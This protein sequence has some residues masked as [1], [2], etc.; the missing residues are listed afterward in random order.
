MRA[1]RKFLPLGAYVRTRISQ[2]LEPEPLIVRGIDQYIRWSIEDAG[3]DRLDYIPCLVVGARRHAEKD[4][5]AVY[6]RIEVKLRELAAQYRAHTNFQPSQSVPSIP[7]QDNKATF[8]TSDISPKP[9]STSGAASSTTTSPST[10]AFN[11]ELPTL[12]GLI[13]VHTIVAL[14]TLDTS[15]D[16]KEL[17]NIALI[18]YSKSDQDVWNGIAIA[19]VAVWARNQLKTLDWPEKEKVEEVDPDL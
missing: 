16:G 19:M 10:H 2:S 12:Y 9:E 8:E 5:K 6:N 3:L 1:L 13:V 15:M 4:V 18:D 11:P 14:V 7:K 17:R